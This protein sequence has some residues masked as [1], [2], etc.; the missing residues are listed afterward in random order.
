MWLAQRGHDVTAVDASAVMLEHTTRKAAAA[1]VT[2]RTVQLDLQR[3]GSGLVGRQFDAVLS[4]FGPLN[5]VQDR[6]GLAAWLAPLLA[7]HAT[8]CAVVMGPLCPWEWL[9]HGAHLDLR[10][11]T[12][13]LRGRVSAHTGGGGTVDVW[14][15]SAR[16]LRREWSPWLK[17]VGTRG[18]GVLLPTSDAGHLVHRLPRAFGALAK[19]ERRIDATLPA[20][21]FNDHYLATFQR[22]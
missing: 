13:R 11:A 5:C 3:P 19:L 7:E 10:A 8:V 4:N 14:Y 9:W 22:R 6:R 17:P 15:P 12:R 16:R 1:G 2:I 18:V 20:T 21:L